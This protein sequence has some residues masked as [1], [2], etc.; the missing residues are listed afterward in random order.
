MIQ[1]AHRHDIPLYIYTLNSIADV[2][3]IMVMGVQGIISDAADDLVSVVKR[4]E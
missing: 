1:D 3:A 4:K 2:R